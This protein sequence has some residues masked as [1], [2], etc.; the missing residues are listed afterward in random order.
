MDIVCSSSG[1][2]NPSQPGQGIMDIANADFKNIFLDL[3]EC[4]PPDKL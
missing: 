1:I 3:S 4:C 2:V